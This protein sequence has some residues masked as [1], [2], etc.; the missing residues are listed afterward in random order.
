MVWVYYKCQHVLS[1][2]QMI[3]MYCYVLQFYR[4]LH[5]AIIAR[6]SLC[7]YLK[8]TILEKKKKRDVK[9]TPSKSDNLEMAKTVRKYI[10]RMY[11]S[12]APLPFVF[13]KPEN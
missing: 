1:Q 8:S 5:A 12:P 13:R 2:S 10:T 9:T 3:A 4:T 6:G 7:V 11:L